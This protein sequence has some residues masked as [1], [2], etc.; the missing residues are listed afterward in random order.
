MSVALL[1]SGVI[2]LKGACTVEDAEV[3]LQF[4]LNAPG[5]QVDWRNCES[6]HTAVVQVLL[7]AN[8][9]PLGL[10]AADFLKDQVA[11]LLKDTRHN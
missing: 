4:L 1:A 6:T 7:A 3:L 10:P 2:E 5:A 9:V 8:L 11:P